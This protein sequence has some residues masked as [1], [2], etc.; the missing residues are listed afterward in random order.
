MLSNIGLVLCL[1]IP[2]HICLC[3]R[4]FNLSVQRIVRTIIMAAAS[5]LALVS[6]K[7]SLKVS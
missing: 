4:I 6:V 7:A 2:S 1:A 3:H 5:V